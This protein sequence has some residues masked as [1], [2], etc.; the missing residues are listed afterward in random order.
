[1]STKTFMGLLINLHI[2]SKNYCHLRIELTIHFVSTH[3]L[4]KYCT[5]T[6][7]SVIK[8]TVLFYVDHVSFHIR[9]QKTR[10][11]R[12]IYMVALTSIPNYW[13]VWIFVESVKAILIVFINMIMV[14]SVFIARCVHNMTSQILGTALLVKSGQAGVLRAQRKVKLWSTVQLSFILPLFCFYLEAIMLP[15]LELILEA[16]NPGDSTAFVRGKWQWCPQQSWKS[17]DLITLERVR[18]FGSWLER[19]KSL[20][21]RN[22]PS[23]KEPLYLTKLE[24]NKSTIQS[25]F[26]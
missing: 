2:R 11:P 1:M 6:V 17:E 4:C 23:W 12:G 15:E 8:L 16:W 9:H 19:R 25:S 14:P 10:R 13:L 5:W 24:G 26:A 22:L 3:I 20:T 21:T 18:R 7:A